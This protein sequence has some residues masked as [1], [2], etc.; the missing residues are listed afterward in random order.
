MT[1]EL[2]VFGEALIDLKA[3][4]A[5][6][7]QGFV[8]GSPLNVALAGARLELPSALATRVSTDFFGAEIA[9]LLVANSVNTDYLERGAEPST[10][11]FVN[12]ASDGVPSYS[13]RF[14]ETSTLAYSGQLELPA[15]L[16]AI[17]YGGSLNPL[18]EPISSR[19]LNIVRGFAGL[20]HFDP[21]VRPAVLGDVPAYRTRLEP[22]WD[23]AD[24]VKMSLEDFEFLYPDS[25]EADFA[26][27]LLA[28]GVRV[29]TVT[30]GG[31][32][33]RLH[34]A[35]RTPL[36]VTAPRIAVVD[37]VGA[38]DT[39]SGA[40]IAKLLELN[41]DLETVTDAALLTVLCFAA[42]AAAIN[43]TRPGCDPPIRAEIAAF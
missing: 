10:L 34:R 15:N 39:F 31:K 23:S 11:A 9:A 25:S 21:N 28:R 43:C 32:G 40:S 14:L 2:L 29:V 27:S 12:V 5:L 41:V 7:F 18:F 19:V 13:F 1:P 37:T 3:S 20:K 8:G 24:W 42:T 4:S 38:G 17:H 35:G 6:A 36:E 30:D 22:W 33:A 16:R 26:A